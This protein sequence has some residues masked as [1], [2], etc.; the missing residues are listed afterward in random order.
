[1]NVRVAS[2][3]NYDYTKEVSSTSAGG[4]HG[5]PP[6]EITPNISINKNTPAG[7]TKYVSFSVPVWEWR[8]YYEDTSSSNYV[9]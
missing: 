1:L 9:N 5:T 6:T 3:E 2:Y 8:G 4:Y 7:S